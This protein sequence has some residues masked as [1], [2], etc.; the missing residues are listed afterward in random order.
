M[1]PIFLLNYNNAILTP[2]EEYKRSYVFYA[3]GESASRRGSAH[4]WPFLCF[5]K[6]LYNFLFKVFLLDFGFKTFVPEHFKFL[7]QL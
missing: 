3:T 7:G 2:I 5:P 1:K 4:R 6:S